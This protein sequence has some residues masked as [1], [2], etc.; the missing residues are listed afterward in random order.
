MDKTGILKTAA[1]QLRAMAKEL[2]ES[3]AKTAQLE[4]A[5]NVVK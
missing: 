3:R 2:T 1:E 4:L 5:I